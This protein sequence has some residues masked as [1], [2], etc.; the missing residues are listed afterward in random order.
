MSDIFH[1]LP[2]AFNKAF[3]ELYEERRKNTDS[4]QMN[5]RIADDML[6][7]IGEIEWRLKRLE[8]FTQDV[9]GFC[10]FYPQKCLRNID[11][12]RTI[13]EMDFKNDK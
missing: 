3:T 1:Q 6:S 10:Q 11:M 5:K 2:D 8:K 13:L 12:M 4:S 7:L 9:G